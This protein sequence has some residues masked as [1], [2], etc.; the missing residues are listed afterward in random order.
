GKSRGI[1]WKD[2][3]DKELI[4]LMKEEIIMFS[5]ENAKTPKEKWAVYKS[6]Q[7]Q[8][9]YKGNVHLR[10]YGINRNHTSRLSYWQKWPHI[11]FLKDTNDVSAEGCSETAK[12]KLELEEEELKAHV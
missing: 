6:V 7:V 2:Q 12:C 9:Q 1:A 8:L 10:I 11:I 3:D 5:L 4:E